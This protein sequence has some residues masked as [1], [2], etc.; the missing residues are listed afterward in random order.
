[1]I[2]AKEE[3]LSVDLVGGSVQSRHG[4]LLAM[5]SGRHT[6]KD[7]R[8]L[9]LAGQSMITILCSLPRARRLPC[10]DCHPQVDDLLAADKRTAGPT[11][12]APASKIFGQRFVHVLGAA[13]TRL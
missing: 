6:T 4:C 2:L 13:V 3:F 11:Q 5:F 12:L 1:M 10:A 9:I 8:R 7:V